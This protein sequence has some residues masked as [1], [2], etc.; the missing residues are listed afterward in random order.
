MS[1]KKETEKQTLK[2]EIRKIG[3]VQNGSPEYRDITAL[4]TFSAKKFCRLYSAKFAEII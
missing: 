3:T 1:R 4:N 2:K